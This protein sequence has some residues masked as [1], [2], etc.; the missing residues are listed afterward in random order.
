MTQTRRSLR[1]GIIGMGGFAAVHHDTIQQL[2]AEGECKLICTCD[3]HPRQFEEKMQ[4]W[5]LGPRGVT[6]FDHYLGMLDACRDQLD[7]VTIPTPVPLHAEMHRA[8]VE[9]GLAVYLEKPPTLSDAELTQ[10]L[11]VEQRTRK[12]TNV[13]FNFIVELP[14]QALKRRLLSREFGRLRKVCFAGLWPRPR[15]YF[16]RTAWAGRLMLDGRLVLDSCLGNAMAHYV[17]NVL[18]W[19]GMGSQLSWGTVEQ[20]ESELYRA[21]TI[22][23]MDTLFV[24]ARTTTGIELQMALTHACDGQHRHREQVVCDDA[25]ITYVTF[26]QY[27]IAWRNGKTETHHVPAV[28][29]KE[30]L[31]AYLHYVRGG[32][33][34]PVTR[35]IDTRPFVQLNDLAYIAA[36]QITTISPEYLRHSAAEDNTAHP[37]DEYVAIKDIDGV[38][39]RFFASGYFP[40]AQGLPWARAGGAAMIDDLPE[41]SRVIEAMAA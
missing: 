29:L 21:H 14:R 40:S 38:F 28:S 1:V 18:F 34:R 27:Q 8:C 19:A 31:L 11:D 12:Q 5:Q 39:D 25:V 4:A 32:L 20:A 22:E 35:L 13:G 10:M 17:H 30:N 24:K 33:D 16:R 3:P 37:A 23:S 41:L 36:G 6:V 26:K 7:V 15:S 9:R 2:E